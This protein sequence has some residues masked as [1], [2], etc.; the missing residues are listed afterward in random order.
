MS[1]FFDKWENQQKKDV[2]KIVF[3]EK[4]KE[5]M[6][7]LSNSMSLKAG[8]ISNFEFKS[9]PENIGWVT[10]LTPSVSAAEMPPLRKK[11]VFPW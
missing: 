1:F 8:E 3:Q 2:K 6:N 9:K 10:K 5:F 4:W 7:F 11:G